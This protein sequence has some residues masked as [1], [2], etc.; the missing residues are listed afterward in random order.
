MTTFNSHRLFPPCLFFLYNKKKGFQ[1]HI[2]SFIL[3]SLKRCG[4][5][6]TIVN[7]GLYF[8]EETKVRVYQLDHLCAQSGSIEASL[9]FHSFDDV[10]SLTLLAQSLPGMSDERK[11]N[12]SNTN[13]AAADDDEGSEN[14]KKKNEKEKSEAS[15]RISDHEAMMNEKRLVQQSRGSNSIQR[16][17]ITRHK[18]GL[19]LASPTS[20]S[21]AELNAEA[22]TSLS[23]EM[24][25]AFTESLRNAKVDESS[26]HEQMLHERLGKLRQYDKTDPNFNVDNR[27]TFSLSLPGNLIPKPS[28]DF[29]SGCREAKTALASSEVSISEEQSKQS[30]PIVNHVHGKLSAHEIMMLEKTRVKNEMAHGLRS[31]VEEDQKLKSA[32]KRMPATIGSAATVTSVDSRRTSSE[33][34]MTEAKKREKANRIAAL[35]GANRDDGI[36]RVRRDPSSLSQLSASIN[37]SQSTV[38]EDKK[39]KVAFKTSPIKTLAAAA[40]AGNV[41]S[42]NTQVQERSSGTE[43]TNEKHWGKASRIAATGVASRLGASWVSHPSQN[44]QRCS[45]RSIDSFTAASIRSNEDSSFGIDEGSVSKHRIRNSLLPSTAPL[46]RV[47]AAEDHD[48]MIMEKRAVAGQLFD[49]ASG[50]NRGVDGACEPPIPELGPSTTPGSSWRS[51]IAASGSFLERSGASGRSV[52]SRNGRDGDSTGSV[53]DSEDKPYQER[54]FRSYL[55]DGLEEQMALN[56]PEGSPSLVNISPGEVF[57]SSCTVNPER[58]SIVTNSACDLLSYD[59]V[60]RH[61][62]HSSPEIEAQVGLPVI[63]PGAFAITGM[64]HENDD[65]YVSAE[66]QSVATDCIEDQSVHEDLEVQVSDQE[67]VEIAPFEATLAEAAVTVDGAV[68]QNDGKL[69][70]KT[71]RR[72]RAMQYVICMLAIGAVALVAISVLSS[73]SSVPGEKPIPTVEGWALVGSTI[74][75]SIDEAGTQFGKAFDMTRDGKRVA[76]VAPGSDDGMVNN[77]GALYYFTEKQGPNGTEWELLTE[78]LKGPGEQTSTFAALAMST[79]PVFIAVGYPDYEN[80]VVMIY[81]ENQV[82][83]EID[84]DVHLAS[85]TSE[86]SWFGYSLDISRD[87]KVLAIGAPRT[88][89]KNTTQIGAVHVFQRNGTEWVQLG[90]PIM[91]EDQDEFSGW[92]VSVVN[93]DGIRVAIGSPVFADFTGRV[94]VLDWTG[95]SW[96]Q[97]GESLEGEGDL[98]RYGDSL[99][100]SRDGK[101]LAVGAR[102]TFYESPGYVTI[103]EEKNGVWA[104]KGDQIGGTADGEGFGADI[105]LSEDGNVI[106]VG[107]PSNDSFGEGSGSI[108]VFEFDAA[109]GSWEQLGSPIGGQP[110]GEFGSSVA[111]DSAGVRVAGGAPLSDFDRRV[112]RAGGVGVFDRTQ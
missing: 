95:T 104:L 78:D 79:D 38:E 8:K 15:T 6:L 10:S 61:S 60:H 81:K 17:T 72:V 86:S 18:A 48:R 96:K 110:Q 53:V 29:D 5:A 109:L 68:I 34:A 84:F 76:V 70:K 67:I 89:T 32:M 14:Y 93:S 82:T 50:N 62:G 106:A 87:G 37:S 102:G 107:A 7:L 27:G 90:K 66:I 39:I 44:S 3:E 80:G 105:A 43:L 71:L 26:R 2:P 112:T 108:R 47:T 88:D 35:G 20:K 55:R 100:L 83:N 21:A 11:Q 31:R 97:V 57:T 94:R 22:V 58:E 16:E 36:A 63:F 19:K 24:M 56:M 59:D 12:A 9:H 103:F 85:N 45:Q 92:S 73:L 65:G 1:K 75:G 28:K 13:G 41:A 42:A 77:V 25:H 69:D 52:A 99:D 101:V 98:N 23:G 111:L 33:S 91:G 4:V 46:A 51:P 40:R 74:V 64:D 49:W 54:R 30:T